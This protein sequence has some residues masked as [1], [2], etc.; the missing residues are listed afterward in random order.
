MRVPIL[1][2]KRRAVDNTAHPSSKF[3]STGLTQNLSKRRTP[4]GIRVSAVYQ[5][6]IEIPNLM[7]ASDTRYSHSDKNVPNLLEIFTKK[8]LILDLP[9]STSEITL[10]C[11][12]LISEK[13]RGVNGQ[14]INTDCGVKQN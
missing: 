8:Q 5:I 11:S 1:V 12:I 4:K 9:V 2:A 7:T 6:L 13:A 14:L 3:A 10:F